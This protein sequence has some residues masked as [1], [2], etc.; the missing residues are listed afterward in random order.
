MDG[1]RPGASAGSNRK[2]RAR[3]SGDA[4]DARWLAIFEDRHGSGSYERL[5]AL[6][7]QPCTTFAEIA[8]QFGVSR[9]RVRQW[10]AQ[11]LP[12]APSGHERQRLCGLQNRKRRLLGDPVFRSFYRHARPHFAPGRIELVKAIDAYRTRSVRIDDRLVAIRDA[13]GSAVLRSRSDVVTYRLTRCR[14]PVD[15]VYYRLAAAD[16]LFVPADIVP[17]GGTMFS[18]APGSKYH[19]FRNTFSAFDV[20][21]P[22]RGGDESASPDNPLREDSHG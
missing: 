7:A 1:G 6:F 2:I 5:L 8:G 19:R 10:Y 3:A 13:S 21:A 15:F 12:G 11:L 16:F 17:V 14:R 9:E 22:G 20:A 18:E 4:V